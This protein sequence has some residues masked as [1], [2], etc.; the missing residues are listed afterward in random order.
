MKLIDLVP[1]VKGSTILVMVER[2][3][4]S[5]VDACEFQLVV[6]SAEKNTLVPFSNARR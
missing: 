2:V 3:E 4:M 5:K 6:S 1:F